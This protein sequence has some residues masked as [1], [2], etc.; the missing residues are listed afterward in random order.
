MSVL[1]FDCTLR[2]G[3][4][5]L[6]AT[7]SAGTG[8]TVLFGPSG[9]GKTT[10]LHLIA[11]LEKPDRGRIVIGSDV[12]TDTS[13]RVFVKPYK[14]RIGLVF[15]DAQLFPHLTVAQN[16]AFGSWFRGRADTVIESDHVIEVLGISQLLSRRPARLSGGEKSRVALARALLSSP[17]LLLMDEPLSGLDEDKRHAILPLIARI[18]DEFHVPVLY[19]THGRDE[20]VRLGDSALRIERG[21]ITAAGPPAQILAR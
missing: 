3:S 5:A 16:L 7:F 4:F 13:A 11:G 1:E 12:L 15:Q 6:D 14:R 9:A 18:R 10:M 19:V 21:R 2:L 17:R 20:A 8:I